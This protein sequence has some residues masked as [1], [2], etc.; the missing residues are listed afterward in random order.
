MINH[1]K[2]KS[3]KYNLL[4]IFGY[5][6]TYL[7]LRLISSPYLDWDEA[8]QFVLAKTFNFGDAHQ[9]P[10]YGW[11]VQ[12]ISLI[13]GYK[14]LSIIIVRYI[15]LSTFL[16]FIYKSA[17][18][19]HSAEKSFL[20][21]NALLATILSY[22]YVINFKLTHSVLVFACS[23]ACFYYYLC[24]LNKATKQNYFLFSLSIALGMLSK[25]NFIFLISAIFFA[26]L[27]FKRTRL[28]IFQT[29]SLISLFTITLICSPYYLWLLRQGSES[30]AYIDK[31]AELVNGDY[32][33]LL[34]FLKLSLNSVFPLIAFVLVS[35]IFFYLS[36]PS[37]STSNSIKPKEN[38]D[39]LIWISIISCLC[40]V[41]AILIIKGSKLTGG[42]LAVTH[43]IVALTVFNFFI[44][45]ISP[46]LQ[47][48]MLGIFFI[49]NLIFFL[50]KVTWI[51]APDIHPKVHR[52]AIPY[53]QIIKKIEKNNAQDFKDINIFCDDQIICANL[54]L[55][56]ASQNIQQFKD[57][58]DLKRIFNTVHDHHIQGKSMIILNSY[59]DNPKFQS[60]LKQLA[61]KLE[62]KSKRTEIKHKYRY[63][64]SQEFNII[65]FSF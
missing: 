15:A 21:T 52:I 18:V 55:I 1:L 58:K 2:F 29:K 30:S 32:N 23:A 65:T 60:K 11:I 59:K 54:E 38:Q 10:L 56:S 27:V 12:S 3:D 47:N 57:F 40:P 50:I 8:E 39:L 14:S 36:K 62:F 13:L 17:R 5:V 22:G 26:R 44:D 43:F 46:K 4:I 45:R 35:V 6:L 7:R 9:A 61:E 24:L 33:Y 64:K 48:Y 51:F 37:N 49:V 28:L 25:F 41:L 20:F 63:S 19:F 53:K 42:W 31:R 16:Y 34:Y